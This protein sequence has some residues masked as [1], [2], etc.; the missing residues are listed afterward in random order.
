MLKRCQHKNKGLTSYNWLRHTNNNNVKYNKKNWDK[1]YTKQI[2]KQVKTETFERTSNNNER[3]SQSRKD[4]RI[5]GQ[6]N[7]EFPSEL[8]DRHSTWVYE[9]CERLTN[10]QDKYNRNKL[11]L[12]CC[13]FRIV[14]ND[15]AQDIF[16][17]AWIYL[18]SLDTLNII[19]NNI[20]PTISNKGNKFSMICWKC[21][22]WRKMT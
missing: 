4:G 15:C 2:G 8:D 3:V 17:E 16:I 14:I 1:D 19:Q 21:Q 12:E 22:V 11:K 13:R 9:K 5:S 10:N 7:Y 18:G 20:Y 6:M